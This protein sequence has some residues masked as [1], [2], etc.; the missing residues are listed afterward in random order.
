M[1]QPLC[2]VHILKFLGDGWTCVCHLAYFQSNYVQDKVP[3]LVNIAVTIIFISIATLHQKFILLKGISSVTLQSLRGAGCVQCYSRQPVLYALISGVTIL[4][5][6]QTGKTNQIQE[7]CLGWD[8]NGNV[9]CGMFGPCTWDVDSLPNHWKWKRGFCATC[10]FCLLYS[11]A[12]I[13]SKLGYF[14]S[15]RHSKISVLGI[16]LRSH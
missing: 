7:T 10:W 16:N 13:L 4:K 9:G 1:Q 8:M 12:K 3:L 15:Q 2:A 5:P 14:S 11:K 6:N